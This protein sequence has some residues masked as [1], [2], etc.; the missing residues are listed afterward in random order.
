VWDL[1]EGIATRTGTEV[2]AKV[3]A[4]R[5]RFAPDKIEANVGDK[6]TMHVT[7]IEQTPDMIHGFGINEHNI[8]IVIDPGETKTLEF[9]ARKPGV[10]PFY[11]TNFCSALHQEMQGYLIVHPQGGAATEAATGENVTEPPV[12]TAP[13][14]G[15]ESVPATADPPVAPEEPP[16]LEPESA[17]P[18]ATEG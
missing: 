13:V 12:M 14:D 9:V 17:S 10:F 2:T 8:N 7:N 4:V 18:A 11:C 15:I 1:K 6:V 16:G 3:V 5:S